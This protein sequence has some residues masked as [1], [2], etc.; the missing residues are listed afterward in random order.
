MRPRTSGG[1]VGDVVPQQL[2]P[3]IVGLGHPQ[4]HLDR[5]RLAGPVAPQEAINGP[6]RN[7]QVQAVDHAPRAVILREPLCH[8]GMRHGEAFPL[9]SSPPSPGSIETA[10]I[11]WIR[12]VILLPRK[13]PGARL[14]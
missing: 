3:A 13:T 11:E 1:K 6:G 9:I 14:P 10:A 7:A 4:Q 12:A 8:D 2:D 5:R